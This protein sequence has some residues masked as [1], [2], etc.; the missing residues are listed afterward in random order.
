LLSQSSIFLHAVAL[1]DPFK[2]RLKNLDIAEIVR[3]CVFQVLKFI[4]LYKHNIFRIF[5]AFI[6]T[7]FGHII[8]IDCTN[9]GKIWLNINSSRCIVVPNKKMRWLFSRQN[10]DLGPSHGVAE[11]IQSS[12]RFQAL[13]SVLIS[14]TLALC[15]RMSGST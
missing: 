6:I 2:L 5:T 7:I 4:N 15:D 10:A 12:R 14:G 13:S 1:S 11:I 3:I 9:W 8:R